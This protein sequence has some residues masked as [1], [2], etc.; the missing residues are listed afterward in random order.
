[1]H[2]GADDVRVVSAAARGSPRRPS[3]RPACCI[4]AASSGNGDE[5]GTGSVLRGDSV[6][7]SEPFSRSVEC[8]R[9]G[10]ESMADEDALPWSDEVDD[11][12]KCTRRASRRRDDD[13]IRR[14]S[15]GT[16]DVIT[17]ASELPMGSNGPL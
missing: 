4:L 9:S 10:S 7:S 11:D 16:D 17:S 15:E 1:V 13:N 14:Q 3:S 12:I 5:A 8:A 2:A 6:R